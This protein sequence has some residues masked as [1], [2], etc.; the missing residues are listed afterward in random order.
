MYPTPGSLENLPVSA[1]GS[2]REARLGHDGCH[3]RRRRTR[4]TACVGVER[5][6]QDA[7][8]LADTGLEGDPGRAEARAAAATGAT[9]LFTRGVVAGTATAAEQAATAATS[10]TLGA[11]GTPA[12]VTRCAHLGVPAASGPALGLRAAVSSERRTVAAVGSVEAAGIAAATAPTAGDDRTIA[13]RRSALADIRGSTTACAG[14]V[15]DVVAAVATA[16]ELPSR[17]TTGRF[18]TRIHPFPPRRPADVAF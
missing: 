4:A 3:R 18:I 2:A 8:A 7:V 17:A 5:D 10:R 9:V 14:V 11:A 16:P 12:A 15:A 6:R 1:P 13:E